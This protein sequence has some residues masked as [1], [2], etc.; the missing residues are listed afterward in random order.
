MIR[1]RRQV[2]AGIEESAVGVE[3]NEPEARTT[4]HAPSSASS[5]A[6]TLGLLLPWMLARARFE[7]WARL[8][9]M[10]GELLILKAPD[11]ASGELGVLILKY[12]GSFGRFHGVYDVPR[13]F[14]DYQLVLTERGAH[15]YVGTFDGHPYV[16]PFSGNIVELCPVG[17]LTSDAYRFRARPWDIEEAGTVC[18]LCPSQCNVK[19]TVRDE[20]AHNR[21]LLP[22]HE[23]EPGGA[24]DPEANSVMLPL[25]SG[26]RKLRDGA[27][28]HLT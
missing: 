11:R 19:I 13:L 27:L 10:G 15:S 12:T 22:E 21:S 7:T 26:R 1:A 6:A 9:R 28:I 25:L 8:V 5:I 18:T 14:E 2:H 16:A 17:A 24:I 23:R 3:V 20:H 4:A